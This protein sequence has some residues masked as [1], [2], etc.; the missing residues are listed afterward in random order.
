MLNTLFLPY[1]SALSSDFLYF[2][3]RIKIIREILLNLQSGC[4]QSLKGLHLVLP[5]AD[6]TIHL[7]PFISLYR[8]F[9]HYNH[10]LLGKRKD[11]HHCPPS[12]LILLNPLLAYFSYHLTTHTNRSILLLPYVPYSY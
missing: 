1:L 5:F 6:I 10:I 8:I 2:P 9:L 12:I 3:F 7:V 4:I 11:E